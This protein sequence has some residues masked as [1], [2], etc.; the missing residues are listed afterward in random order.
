MPLIYILILFFQYLL[1]ESR[2]ITLC[3]MMEHVTIV[4][5]FFVVQEKNKNK[6]KIKEI[7]NQEK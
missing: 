5:Y 3:Y 4:I 2:P 6:N 7:L 1:P